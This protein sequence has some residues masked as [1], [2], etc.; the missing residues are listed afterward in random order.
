MFVL[1]SSEH[2]SITHWFSFQGE[3]EEEKKEQEVHK[4]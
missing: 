2:V 4:W 1:C 3:D